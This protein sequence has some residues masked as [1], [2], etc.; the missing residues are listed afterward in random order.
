MGEAKRKRSS[1]GDLFA[2]E[3]AMLI[4]DTIDEIFL[5]GPVV[6]LP[7]D[8]AADKECASPS[9]VAIV[10]GRHGATTS[11]P[12]PRTSLTPRATA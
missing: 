2:K 10:E 6:W 1:D 3:A 11:R 9:P 8:G 12:T 5:F 4:K 7:V